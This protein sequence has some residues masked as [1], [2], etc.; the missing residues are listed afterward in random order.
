MFLVIRLHQELRQHR[1]V[2]P[3]G[4]GHGQG[5]DQSGQARLPP[6]QGSHRQS[7][8]VAGCVQVNIIHVD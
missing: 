5:E 3:G 4:G 7:Q 6:V 1:G 8:A 2:S